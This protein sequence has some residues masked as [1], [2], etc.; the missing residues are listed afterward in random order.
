MA[1]SSAASL[2]PGR[3]GRE[4]LTPGCAGSGAQK[5]DL[6]SNIDADASLELMVSP[7]S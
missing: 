4:A 6:Q 7:A 2:D 5:Q 3:G 1:D